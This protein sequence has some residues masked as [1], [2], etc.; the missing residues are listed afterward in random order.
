MSYRTVM[1]REDVLEQLRLVRTGV[2]R[3]VRCNEM[4]LGMSPMVKILL[5]HFEK[6]PPDV[7]WLRERVAAAPKR[8]RPPITGEVEKTN[9]WGEIEVVNRP[10]PKTRAKGGL[11]H[12]FVSPKAN[13]SLSVCKHCSE[14][15]TGPNGTYPQGRGIPCG[16][17]ARR[18]TKEELLA[19]QFTEE[20]VGFLDDPNRQADTGGT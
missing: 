6:V 9:Q 15:K 1:V 7:Q 13:P 12:V 19:L 17:D 10:R 4:S 5:D 11:G 20:E 18:H 14:F 3:L 16:P 8:G 2:S